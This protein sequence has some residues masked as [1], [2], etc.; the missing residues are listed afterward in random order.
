M[1]ATIEIVG[2][3]IL[4]RLRWMSEFEAPLVGHPFDETRVGASRKKAGSTS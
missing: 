3:S 4:G 1:T 2:T